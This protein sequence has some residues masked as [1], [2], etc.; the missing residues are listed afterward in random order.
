MHMS[1]HKC[2][3]L[4]SLTY[5]LQQSSHKTHKPKKSSAAKG[6]L[7]VLV[8]TWWVLKEYIGNL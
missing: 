7:W 5:S 1:T 4:H 8:A 3:K 6:S 2:L